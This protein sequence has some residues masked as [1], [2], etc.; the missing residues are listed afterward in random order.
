LDRLL[1]LPRTWRLLSEALH[2]LLEGTPP[3]VDLGLLARRIRE[4]PGVA[5]V[6]DLHVWAIT[7]GLN[8]MSAHV[9]VHDTMDGPR[10]LKAV[11]EAMKAD[12][13]IDHVTVQI[14]DAAHCDGRAQL[15]A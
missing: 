10:V 12:F 3:E 8:S 1:I 13:E 9:L 2:I 15:H 7:S 4:I 5:G 11:C 6:H 14:E